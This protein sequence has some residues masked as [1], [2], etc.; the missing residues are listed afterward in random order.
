MKSVKIFLYIIA[1]LMIVGGPLLTPL[2][3]L[4]W[5]D[6]SEDGRPSYTMEPRQLLTGRIIR[7]APIIP[8]RLFSIQSP[9]V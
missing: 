6:N 7:T 1:A 9:T 4:A 5:G 2:S 3:A 8:V